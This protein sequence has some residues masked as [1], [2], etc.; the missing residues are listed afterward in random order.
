MAWKSL[1]LWL[2]H[3][4]LEL[5]PVTLLFT[6]PS[7]SIL[8]CYEAHD[9]HASRPWGSVFPSVDAQEKSQS[10]ESLPLST[11]V[12]PSLLDRAEFFPASLLRL[13]C[14]LLK[15]LSFL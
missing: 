1:P 5:P 2:P 4:S 8:L 9:L 6:S 10:C 11:W 3:G 14:V 15:H 13:A 7:F 12:S